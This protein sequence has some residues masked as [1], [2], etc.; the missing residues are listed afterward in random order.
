MSEK[1]KLF[2]L[3]NTDVTQ[4]KKVSE[5]LLTYEEVENVHELYG[6]YDIIIRVVADNRVKAEEFLEKEIRHNP[7]VRRTETLVV[8]EAIKE[9]DED[10]IGLNES[11]VYILITVKYGEKRKVSDKLAKRNEVGGVYEIYGQFDVI[12]KIKAKTNK[13]LEDFIQKNIRSIEGVEGT[14][15]LVVSDVP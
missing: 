12:A 11:E 4:I 5:K 15:T 6:Q 14:E 2:V 7:G 9:G 3:M 13:E 1:F 8:S 10:T